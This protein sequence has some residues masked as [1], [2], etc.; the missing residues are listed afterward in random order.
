MHLEAARRGRGRGPSWQRLQP[1]RLAQI[2]GAQSQGGGSGDWMCVYVARCGAHV[3]PW[4]GDS[5]VQRWRNK[6]SGDHA[7][8]NMKMGPCACAHGCGSVCIELTRVCVC[9]NWYGGVCVRVHTW[10][11]VCMVMSYV[12]EHKGLFVGPKACA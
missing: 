4:A 8:V 6:V 3:C 10:K 11:H 7:C 12:Q 9:A 1:A 5:W 2:P